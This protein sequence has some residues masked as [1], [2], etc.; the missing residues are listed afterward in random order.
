M[1]TLGVSYGYHDSSVALVKDGELLDFI[2]EERL[3]NVK[4]DSN[5]PEHAIHYC[6]KKNNLKLSDIDRVAFHEDPF[7]K[8]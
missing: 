3:S 1:I 6:L 5:F 2:Y 4:H 8:F 7:H